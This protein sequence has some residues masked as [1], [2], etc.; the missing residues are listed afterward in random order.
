VRNAPPAS[1]ALPRQSYTIAQKL[2]LL[3]EFRKVGGKQ[4]AFAAKHN[5]RQQTL[6]L[7]LKEEKHL[8]TLKA[9]GFGKCKRK[10]IE[11]DEA[12]DEDVAAEFEKDV[13]AD[14]LA[15]IPKTPSQKRHLWHLGLHSRRSPSSG[16]DQPRGQRQSR[17]TERIR[18]IA[19]FAT[20]LTTK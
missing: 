20:S 11:E 6:S 14:A 9:R 19:R 17:A 4:A 15:T 18:R 13:D 12:D 7:W 8:L 16:F 2:R 10:G 3:Q 5:M 1:V